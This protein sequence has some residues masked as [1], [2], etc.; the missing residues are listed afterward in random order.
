MPPDDDLFPSEGEPNDPGQLPEGT[1]PEEPKEGLTQR[2]LEQFARQFVEPNTA[3]MQRISDNQTALAESIQAIA[4][5]V[6][7]GGD[8]PQ[9]N[10]DVDV[11]EFLS[12][13]TSHISQI[14]KSEAAEAVREQVAPLLGQL[15][16]QT[17]QETVA[18]QERTIDGEFGK[19]AWAEHFWPDLKPIFD[20]TQ[21][22]AP[23]QLGNTEAIQRAVDT[24]K[25]AKFSALADARVGAA[26]SQEEAKQAEIEGLREI[27][28]SNMTGGITRASGK[29]SLSPEMKAYVEAEFRA[30]GEKPNEKD[31]LAS[32]NSGSTLK[33]WQEAQKASKKE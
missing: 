6:G 9:D 8:Q 20:R 12:D 23:S 31:F 18:N 14:A 22:E 17:Y 24:I 15:V 25:G 21:K 27:V 4:T 3:Q 32:V 10:Q 33:E 11:S 7:M 16:Q 29:M 13:P 19:G 5:R 30:T 2:D 1:S 26:K 28:Q